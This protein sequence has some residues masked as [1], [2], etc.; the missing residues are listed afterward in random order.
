MRTMKTVL[1]AACV[2]FLTMTLSACGTLNTTSDET[3]SAT[4]QSSAEQDDTNADTA[5]AN[6][7]TDAS[8]TDTSNETSTMSNQQSV[9]TVQDGNGTTVQFEL[10]GS[11]AAKDL[12]AQLPLTVEVEDFSTNEK[13]FYPETLDVSDT[14]LAQVAV[15]TLAYY[16][17]WG[18][19]VMF[20][21]TYRSNSALYELGHV[22][23]GGNDI[24]QLSGTITISA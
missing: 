7:S 24:N 17:P 1:A 4:P 15:G 14:P 8:T 18:D 3:L 12:L 5:D 22:T 11:S 10:N 9:I 6:A 13:I 2:V 20:F 16:E 23:A 21:D 19:V